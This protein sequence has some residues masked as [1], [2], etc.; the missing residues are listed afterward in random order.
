MVVL[1]SVAAE[2]GNWPFSTDEAVVGWFSAM[3]VVPHPAAAAGM[4]EAA[5]ALR[6]RAAA[7][8][9][10]AVTLIMDRIGGQPPLKVKPLTFTKL[11]LWALLNVT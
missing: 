8:S 5:G 11:A 2:A 4:A 1:P 9:N 7:A 6:H 3:F 10:A